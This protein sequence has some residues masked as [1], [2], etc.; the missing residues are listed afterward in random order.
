VYNFYGAPIAI[1]HKVDTELF[2]CQNLLPFKSCARGGDS[3]QCEPMKEEE[4]AQAA[5][6]KLQ[7]FVIPTPKPHLL[8]L[9]F[10]L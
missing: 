1:K 8:P 4:K 5:L 3:H 9:F 10:F 7:A 2:T 6:F